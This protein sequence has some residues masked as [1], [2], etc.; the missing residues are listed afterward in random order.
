[1]SRFERLMGGWRFPVAALSLLAFGTLL[2]AAMLLMPSGN[3]AFHAFAE[4]FRVWCFGYDPA[5]GKVETAYVVMVLTDP[6]VLAAVIVGVWWRPLR[7][8][9]KSGLR[10]A[11]PWVAGVGV[12]VF[13][14]AGALAATWK[15]PARDAELPFPAERLRTEIPA[16]AF[17]L[18]DQAGAKV[19]LADYT[20]KIVLLTG[21]YS[22]CGHT[23]PLILQ[24]AKHAIEA[25]APEVRDR[26]TVLAV[27]L[28]PA[29]DTPARMENMARMQGLSAPQFRLLTGEPATV[30][31]L[32]D[33]LGIERRRNADGPIDH[34]N[35]FL[36]VDAQGRIA[37]RL[38][39]GERQQHWLTA[40]LEQVVREEPRG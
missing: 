16:P 7:A 39:L 24:Q 12:V 38:A 21:V 13:G 25:M 4:E 10:R 3:T 27:T 18:T 22:T 5:T 6:L 9:V 17:T 14:G 36:V 34:T 40:A 32:L 37:Y 23:C 8:L 35:L 11:A 30:E 28:D 20:G 26:V 2:S 15:G 31:P 33:R 1:M 19:S 29:N